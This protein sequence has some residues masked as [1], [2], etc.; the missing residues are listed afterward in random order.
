MHMMKS[1]K[2]GMTIDDLAVMVA[3][4]FSEVH[5]LFSKTDEKVSKIDERLASLEDG[6]V[7]IRGDISSLGDRYV[8]KFDFDRLLMRFLK[9][10]EKVNKSKR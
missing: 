7:K 5:D 9:L 10:E 4:G 3:K 6:Q 1:P 2:K 8:S